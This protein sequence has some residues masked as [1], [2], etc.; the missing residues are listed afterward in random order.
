MYFN[1]ILTIFFGLILYFI[2][3]RF[4]KISADGRIVIRVCGPFA[5]FIMYFAMFETQTVF[6]P[7][8]IFNLQTYCESEPGYTVELVSVSEC[9][10][11]IVSADYIGV[12][13]PLNAGKKFVVT[14]GEVYYCTASVLPNKRLPPSILTFNKT[15]EIQ[16][17]ESDSPYAGAGVMKVYSYKYV[18]WWAEFF[19][20][21]PRTEKRVFFIPAGTLG[22]GKIVIPEPAPIFVPS[23]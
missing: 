1:F 7:T 6:N 21:N 20:S 8:S 22:K 3:K 4:K 17:T 23:S 16:I 9:C 15:D 18:N 10:K 14:D 12:A 2:T 5:V 11:K 19:F 13:N